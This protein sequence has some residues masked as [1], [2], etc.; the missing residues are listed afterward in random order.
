[1][2]TASRFGETNHIMW[3][4]DISILA[5]SP[6]LRVAC[7]AAQR[8]N[9][10]LLK[11][12][13]S[14]FLIESK[15]GPDLVTA[16]DREAEQSIVETLHDHYPQHVVLAEE[17][18]RHLGSQAEHLWIVDPLDGTTNFAHGVSHFA[19]SIGYY[20]NG[21]AQCGVITNPVAQDWFLTAKGQGAWRNK[22]RVLVSHARSLDQALIATGFYYDRGRM[23]ESTLSIIHDLFQANIHGIRRFGAAAL[24]LAMVGCGHFEGFFELHLQPWDFAAGRLF[25]EEAGGNL[26]D[27]AGSQLPL[28][29]SSS[30][31]A[32]NGHIHHLVEQ[33][34]A[35][36]WQSFR[37]G[38]DLGMS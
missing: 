9:E 36:H 20:R 16:A 26:T 24:D 31:L 18:H 28:S 13:H 33:V 30:I 7:I 19:V 21:I 29:D 15:G 35:K 12:F 2:N 6:E 32:T 14:H 4:P 1:M 8:A 37:Q 38:P 22:K 3:T 10:V 11:H 5:T 25:V 27:L 23:M 17:S 34:A